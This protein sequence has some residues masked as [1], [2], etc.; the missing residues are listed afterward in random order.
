MLFRS[1]L[2]TALAILL[3]SAA[4]AQPAGPPPPQAV[5]ACAGLDNGAACRF[6]APHGAVAGAC[7]MVPGGT[8]ACVPGRPGGPPLEAH[9]IANPAPIPL[10][11]RLSG[12][13]QASCYDDS[14]AIPC[15]APGQPFFGQDASY[16]GHPSARRDNGDGTITDPDTGLTWQKAHQSRRLGFA[17]A[18]ADCAALTLAGQADWRLPTIKELFS[19]ADF[20]GATGRRFFLDGALFDFAPPGAE[21]LAGDPFAATHQPEM[22]GQTWSS[23]LYVA[24]HAGRPG[25]RAAFFFNFLD[26]RIKQA[27]IDGRNLLFHR[28]VRGP[29][30]GVNQFR[31]R[32]DGTVA[33][34]LTGL[35]WQRADDG[36][37]RDWGEALA[38]CQSLA[39]AGHHDWRL[40]NI[41]ELHSIVDY[42]RAD[43]ALDTSV[44]AQ[45]DPGGWFWSSTTHGDDPHDAAYVCFGPCSSTTGI[46]MHGA[47]A[48]RSDPKSGDPAGRPGRGGQRDEVR[49]RNYARCVR[50]DG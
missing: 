46:D 2:A 1:F 33:D 32:G 16:A 42:R 34:G 19:I 14:R 25:V 26:G 41:R 4:L 39:L 27:P 12:T 38:Y 35:L 48:Q 13:G 28:C 47:G 18:Q 43:P 30:W 9:P 29:E 5:A 49:I 21:V 31:D 40:P 45:R 37:R 6:Q 15:P 20:R 23:T 36:R 10:H 17:P 3:T 7:R 8:S 44:L 24:D 11:N 22:M 50:D